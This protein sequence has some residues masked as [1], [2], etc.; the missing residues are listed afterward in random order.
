MNERIR[1]PKVR[2]I[3][4]QGE[5][6]GVMHPRQALKFAK[7]CGFDLVEVAPNASPPVCRLMDYGKWKYERSKKQ[8]NSNSG[9]SVREVKLRPK[10]AEHD[11]EVKSRTVNRLLDD[12]DKVKITMRLRGREMS[13]EDRAKDILKRLVEDAGQLATVASRPS[14]Q[15]RTMSMVLQ[16]TGG[17]G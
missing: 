7:E 17:A 10:I 8:D 1:A 2:L 3:D 12:G 16:P 15:G 11:Y 14:R 13:H 5:A 4:H 6:Q 9:P